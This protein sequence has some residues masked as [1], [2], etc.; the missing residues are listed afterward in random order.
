MTRK[1]GAVLVRCNSCGVRGS[2]AEWDP[3]KRSWVCSA[4]E[5]SITEFR[6]ILAEAMR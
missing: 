5:M 2:L 1:R 4:C 3:Q 6:K